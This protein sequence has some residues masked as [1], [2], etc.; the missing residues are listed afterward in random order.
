MEDKEELE[1]ASKDGSNPKVENNRKSKLQTWNLNIK[2]KFQVTSG[3]CLIDSAYKC[4]SDRTLSRS[5][6]DAALSK[7]YLLTQLLRFFGCPG[8][9]K[10]GQGGKDDKRP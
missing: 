3:G 5:E 2:K 9:S 4:Q 10:E 6:Y 8:H 7:H 1:E